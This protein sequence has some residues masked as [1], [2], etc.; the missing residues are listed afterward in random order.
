MNRN[1]ADMRM[2]ETTL[3][4]HK[5]DRHVVDIAALCETRLADYRGKGLPK[6]LNDR[7][8]SMFPPLTGYHHQNNIYDDLDSLIKAVPRS[9]KRIV[10]D[11]FNARN[12]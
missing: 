4:G 9:D 8:M 6:G 11:D 1:N 12:R 5:L 3:V 7:F 2:R 10:L